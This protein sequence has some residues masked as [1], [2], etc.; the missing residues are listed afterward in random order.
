MLV[1]ILM[2]E[3]IRS[4]RCPGATSGGSHQAEGRDR[5][6]H[7]SQNCQPTLKLRCTLGYSEWNLEGSREGASLRRS[8]ARAG[9]CT[10]NGLLCG[11]DEPG[12]INTRKLSLDTPTS[13]VIAMET[14]KD[15]GMKSDLQIRSTAN[16]RPF[17]SW[18]QQGCHRHAV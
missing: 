1:K 3:Q 15:Q 6:S 12:A 16:E 17:P 14:C 5:E 18:L 8:G 10:T 9:T 7:G 13:Y 2:A 11:N 4:V